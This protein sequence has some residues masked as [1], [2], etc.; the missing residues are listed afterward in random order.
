MKGTG[1]QWKVKSEKLK[2]KSVRQSKEP[3]RAD[4][5]FSI[6]TSEKPFL[7]CHSDTDLSGEESMRSS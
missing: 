4:L 3:R 7:V 2:V 5:I 6:E 1:V